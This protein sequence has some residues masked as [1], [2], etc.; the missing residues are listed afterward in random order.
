M[1]PLVLTAAAALLCALAAPAALADPA[2]TGYPS[3]IASTG[4]S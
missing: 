2:V 1:K 4:D 3:S